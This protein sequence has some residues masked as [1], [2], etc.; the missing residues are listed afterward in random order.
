MGGKAAEGAVSLS[1]Q[2]G[3]KADKFSGETGIGGTEDGVVIQ[4]IFP[5]LGGSFGLGPR[6]SAPRGDESV[7]GGE[8]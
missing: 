5:G 8:P 7:S 4:D 2:G 1:L 3:E 6:G